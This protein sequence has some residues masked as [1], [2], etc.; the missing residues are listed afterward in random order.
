MRT[1]ASF[2]LVAV[3]LMAGACAEK[4]PTGPS[5]VVLNIVYLPLASCPSPGAVECY[6]GCAHHYAPSNLRVSGSWGAEQ[7]LTACGEAYC[8]TLPGAPVDRELTTLVIDIAQCC[9]DCS[10]PVRETVSVNGT[11][12]TRFVAGTGGQAGGL[13]FT[14]DRNGRVTP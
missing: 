11:R 3:L 5:T 4:G 8:A 6:A 10:A 2:G 9:R 1:R 14:V 12:L 7:R 13:A